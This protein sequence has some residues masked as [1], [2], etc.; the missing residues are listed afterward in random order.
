MGGL[1]SSVNLAKNSSI[2]SGKKI[3]IE[4]FQEK[5]FISMNENYVNYNLPSF[6]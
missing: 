6:L 2:E 3:E 5:M 4:M 1:K